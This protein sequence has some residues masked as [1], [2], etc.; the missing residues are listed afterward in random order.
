MHE[1]VMYKHPRNLILEDFLLEDR[2]EFLPE[3]EA[4]HES[5]FGY[6]KALPDD[7]D[8]HLPVCDGYLLPD[9]LLIDCD[10]QL[11]I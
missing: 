11:Q 4:A 10:G 7:M 1:L 9:G 2:Y 5:L 6:P 8:D 3:V